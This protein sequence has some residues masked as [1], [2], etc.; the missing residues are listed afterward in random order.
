MKKV[1][2]IMVAFMISMI[3][4]AQ[5]IVMTPSV[6]GS[7]ISM[8]ITNDFEFTTFGFKLYLP[9]GVT[10]GTVYDE[11]EEKDVPAVIKNMDRCKG[12]H[13]VD[14]R[15]TND[16]GWSVN[17]YGNKTSFKGNE[18]EVCSIQL[19]GEMKGTAKIT[20]INFGDAD[21]KAYF[22]EEDI[23]LELAGT[24]VKNIV[25]TPSVDGS[26]IS[27]SITNDFEFTTFGFKLYLPEGVTLGTV[28]DE[29]EE[30]D[31]P[32][33]IKNMDRCKGSHIVDCR[34]TNDGG[35]S[36]NIYGNK[37]SFKGNEGEVCSIQLVGEMKGTAKITFINF[38]DA[39][40][41]AYFQE[42]DIN[43]ELAGTGIEGVDAAANE[44]APMYNLAGQRVSRVQKG[45]FIQNGKKVLK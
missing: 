10:L 43:L 31:V 3:A 25:M 41:K 18:G 36:V 13:I 2:M 4:T 45:I 14:C 5:N 39:D 28:Y 21:G 8:S 16:G 12:S 15:E 38:G 20:F 1:F 42:E 23:N 7:T 44:N 9:E 29:D 33:V 17:I 40:G 24:D 37:T 27:M 22:Q 19:V 11:D 30:K 6:D 34:E 35:W 32:A 26:T